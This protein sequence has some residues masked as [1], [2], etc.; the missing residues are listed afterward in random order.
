MLF[1]VNNIFLL[2][3]IMINK[4]IKEFKVIYYIVCVRFVK[5]SYFIICVMIKLILDIIKYRC[6]MV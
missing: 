5:F 4:K 1:L 3:Y 2:Y 6:C